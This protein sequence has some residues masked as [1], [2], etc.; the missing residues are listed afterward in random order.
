MHAHITIACLT[1]MIG[2]SDP[3]I[4]SASSFLL[5]TDTSFMPSSSGSDSMLFVSAHDRYFERQD[6]IEAYRAQKEIQ[7]PEYTELT[8]DAMVSGRLRVRGEEVSLIHISR[9]F[10]LVS[11][12]AVLM[13][14]LLRRSAF[15]RYIGRRLRETAS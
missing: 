10:L 3:L 11:K 15:C 1:V 14:S 5:T 9:H 4:P 2:E 13:I 8:E 6:V 7:T 12:K